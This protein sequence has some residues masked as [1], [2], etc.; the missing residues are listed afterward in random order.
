M[1]SN[2]LYGKREW[3]YLYEWLMHFA[4][5][6]KWIQHLNQLCSNKIKYFFKK[7]VPIMAQ[8]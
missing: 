3:K 1:Y 5:H 6:L 7:G 2:N 4:G 8:Q